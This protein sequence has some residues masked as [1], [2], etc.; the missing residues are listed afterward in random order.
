MEDD[1]EK[2]MPNFVGDVKNVYS[3]NEIGQCSLIN[4]YNLRTIKSFIAYEIKTIQDLALFSTEFS[5]SLPMHQML[6][7]FHGVVIMIAYPHFPIELQSLAKKEKKKHHNHPHNKA[8]EH[9]ISLFT[10]NSHLINNG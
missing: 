3:E 5:S 1:G 8:E 2:S 6:K 9:L 10:N 7:C 4:R